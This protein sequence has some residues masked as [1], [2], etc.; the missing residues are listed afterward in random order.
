MINIFF[1]LPGRSGYLMGLAT[2]ALGLSLASPPRLRVIAL[3]FSPLILATVLAFSSE[4]IYE[5]GSLLWSE[6]TSESA[7]GD[8]SKST[9]FRLAAWQASAAA[10]VDRPIL[11]F[12]V[13]GW[14]TAIDAQTKGSQEDKRPPLRGNNPH[15][16]FLLWG[17]ELGIVGVFLACGLFVAIYID[18]QRFP[19]DL[20]WATWSVGLSLL[21]ASFFNSPLYDDLLGDYFCVALGLVL[22]YGRVC[23]SELPS[24]AKH[25]A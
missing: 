14:A 13:G 23:S 9:S 3:F 19:S 5:R 4:R 1:L 6:F 18:A 7:R 10:L 20:K 24:M 21:V 25:P 15:Q 22:A 11:G 12:G 2:F 8:L 16:Q 17:V